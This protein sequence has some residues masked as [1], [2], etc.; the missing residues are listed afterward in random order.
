MWEPENNVDKTLVGSVLISLF[1][2]QAYILGPQQR[3]AVLQYGA[4]VRSIRSTQQGVYNIWNAAATI[5][6][7]RFEGIAIKTKKNMTG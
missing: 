4:A 7:P 1:I 3:G 5:P 2:K 6:P